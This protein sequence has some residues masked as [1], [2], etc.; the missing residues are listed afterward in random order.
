[1]KTNI[2]IFTLL[3]F[4]LTFCVFAQKKATIKFEKIEHDFGTIKE[5][6]G[7]VKCRY[8][9][10]NEGD[11]TLRILSVKPGCGCTTADWTKTGIPPKKSGYVDA[12]YDPA[13]RPGIFNKGINVATNDPAQSVITLIIKGDVIPKAKG[14]MDLYPI[15][16]GNLRFE[17]G[18][19]NFG[20]AKNTEIRCDTLKIYNGWNTALTIKYKDLPLYIT[21][22]IIPEVLKPGKEGLLI[23]NYDVAKRNDYGYLSDRVLISTNDSMQPDKQINISMNIVEDFSQ[24]TPEQKANA[25]I[26]K[27]EKTNFNFVSAK[28]GEK[29]ECVYTFSNQGKSDLIIRKIKA[30]CGCTATYPEKTVLKPGESSKITATLN[31]AGREG[32]QYKTISVICNDPATPN[33]A[34][35]LEGLVEKPVTNQ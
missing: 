12:E 9:F 23:I 24:L 5:E 35:S 8:N 18:Q 2:L 4:G 29:V 10:K 34:L 6:N 11:D 7:K 30:S 19:F 3:F 14:I 28:Q 16:I 22:K 20:N 13:Q 15:V 17:S 33:V 1:M 27:F 25:P 31:T 32:K 26:I 21:G